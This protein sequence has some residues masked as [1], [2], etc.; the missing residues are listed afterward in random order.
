WSVWLMPELGGSYE[1]V[2][3]TLLDY[4]KRDHRWCQGNLQHARVFG[5]RGL[6]PA[7]RFHFISGIMSY[8][9]S[10][11]WL[12]F[13]GLGLAIAAINTLFPKAYF[14]VQKQLFPDW[15]IF[16]A[17]LAKSLF[18]LALGFLLVPR[19]LGVLLVLVDGPTRRSAGGALRVGIGSAIELVYSTL[20]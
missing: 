10:P 5:A 15:P 11:L 14:G 2:P 16:D 1:E 7:S 13:L 8:V 18:L 17:A 6:H 9:A 4:A 3:P 20:L 19:L 12:M